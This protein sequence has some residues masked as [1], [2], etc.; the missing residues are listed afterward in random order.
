ILGLIPKIHRPTYNEFYEQRWFDTWQ[1]PNTSVDI[2]GQSVPF[3][4]NLLFDLDGALVGIEIC[5]DLWVLQPP[6]LA[7]VAKGAQVVVNPSASPEQIGKAGYRHEL[8]TTQSAR[9]F[10]AYVY[11]GCDASESTSE[12]VMGGHQLIASNGQLLAERLPF[13]SEPLT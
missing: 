5:E 9:M 12:V 7:L 3:G 1:E 4:S 11:A 10:G 6:S 13:G 8:V 2:E